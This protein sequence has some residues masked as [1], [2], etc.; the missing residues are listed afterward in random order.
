MVNEQKIISFIEMLKNYSS[1][2]RDTVILT[3]ASLILFKDFPKNLPNDV[4]ERFSKLSFNFMKELS[5]KQ[6][7]Y[8]ETGE[9]HSQIEF[10]IPGVERVELPEYTLFG[11]LITR[12]KEKLGEGKVPSSFEDVENLLVGDYEQSI[13]RRQL[14]MLFT[15]LESFLGD[16]LRFIYDIKPEQLL[17]YKSK[18]LTYEEIFSYTSIDDLRNGIIDKLVYD[19]GWKSL[20]KQFKRFS[21]IGIK[22]KLTK[23]EEQLLYEFEQV[24]HIIVHNICRVNEKFVKETNRK[25][26]AI[27]EIYLLTR[28]KMG[29]FLDIID[30]IFMQIQNGIAEKFL[31]EKRK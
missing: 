21:N 28:T 23:K 3:N 29:E 24:R 8:K 13:Q 22:I 16:C 1:A 18:Q 9:F 2:I 20:S 14:I 15:Y 19:F 17:T 4:S 26:L 27:N 30:K 10:S 25:D 11:N 31:R 5:E 6:K 12:L 7:L